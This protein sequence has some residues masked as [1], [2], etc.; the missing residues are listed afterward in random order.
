MRMWVLSLAL[1]SGLRDLA[2]AMRCGV[3]PRCGSDLGLL[4]LWLAATALIQ[5]LA[6]ELPYA[7]MAIK[8]KKE[9]KKR[10][11]GE[12]IRRVKNKVIKSIAY[13]KFL[14]QE[15]RQ[16]MEKWGKRYK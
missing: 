1:L 10:R 16:S 14:P 7:T 6:W 13:N 12:G 5:P 8:K 4:W 15:D 2:I 9:R 11:V 3:G